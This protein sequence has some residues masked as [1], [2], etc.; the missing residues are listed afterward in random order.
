MCDN[1]IS[2]RQ[3]K[4]A[5]QWGSRDEG[6]QRKLFK[7]TC[8]AEESSCIP[9][10]RKCILRRKRS[11]KSSGVGRSNTISPSSSIFLGELTDDFPNNSNAHIDSSSDSSIKQVI[12][13]T[14]NHGMLSEKGSL[15]LE[16][17][18]E[19]TKLMK[20][21]KFPTVI[22]RIKNYNLQHS[23]V[24][25]VTLEPDSEE[26]VGQI[27][28]LMFSSHYCS[29]KKTALAELLP[30]RVNKS[31]WEDL[32]S[33]TPMLRNRAYKNMF[34]NGCNFKIRELSSGR[35]A[36]YECPWKLWDLRTEDLQ[37]VVIDIIYEDMR[38]IPRTMLRTLTPLRRSET[39]KKLRAWSDKVLRL[40][41]SLSTERV[42]LSE[43]S[44]GSKL[45]NCSSDLTF[46]GL[47]ARGGSSFSEWFK[48][49]PP[50]MS[51]DKT[52]KCNHG[53]I[54]T[55]DNFSDTK[56]LEKYLCISKNL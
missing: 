39:F 32:L 49:V 52:F 37:K 12:G 24:Y 8:V 47:A 10:E 41:Q 17:V 44:Y 38:Q 5:N 43:E 22:S 56:M 13:T 31:K 23:M 51:V 40:S 11:N 6:N 9:I 1:F 45:S 29:G 26:F 34:R 15:S 48:N 50:N 27:P 18:S 53:T 21:I 35:V 33:L 30:L 42:D 55:K 7:D 19:G 54:L 3:I 36:D 16:V 2:N 20:S 4:R 46:S 14:G 28:A 25:Y